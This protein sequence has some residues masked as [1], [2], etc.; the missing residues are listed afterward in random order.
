[1]GGINE[2]IE[3]YFRSCER[4]GLTGQQG[5][6]IPRR[7]RRHLMLAPQI[8]EAVAQGRFRIWTADTAGE[9]MA[10]LSGLPYGEPGP[11]GYAPDTVLGRAQ[12][13]LL[14]YRKACQASGRAERRPR[15]LKS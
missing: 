14:E 8:V 10:L 15:L 12:R 5:V 3:G 4:L 13:T 7:N 9:G 6:L 1:V 2:K 11:G